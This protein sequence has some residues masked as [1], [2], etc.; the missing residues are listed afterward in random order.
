[1]CVCVCVLSCVCICKSVIPID[2]LSVLW[3]DTLF[4]T[5]VVCVASLFLDL[6]FPLSCCLSAEQLHLSKYLSIGTY[7]SL[8]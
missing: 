8:I 4:Y 5:C 6:N 2:C 7:M 3:L 1:M